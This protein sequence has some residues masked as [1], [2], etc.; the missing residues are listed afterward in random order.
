VYT[1]RCLQ[2]ADRLAL[3]IFS[4]QAYY[5][6]GVTVFAKGACDF[7][8]RCDT[9]F[10]T[11]LSASAVYLRRGIVCAAPMGAHHDT[12]LLTTCDFVLLWVGVGYPG[13]LHALREMACYH[14]QESPTSHHLRRKNQE[15]GYRSYCEV[16]Q[17]CSAGSTMHQITAPVLESRRSAS[18]SCS[19]SHCTPYRACNM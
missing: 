3:R 14:V 17:Q 19:L 6:A 13:I 18:I 7:L 15:K 8:E 2:A 1:E 12:D 11:S 10:R 5:T 4:P 16:N 9:G